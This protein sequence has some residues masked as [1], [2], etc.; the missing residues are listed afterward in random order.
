MA[1]KYRFV[2]GKHKFFDEGYVYCEQ[3]EWNGVPHQKIVIVYL[4]IRPANKP[5]FI[6]KYE[7]YNYLE[8]GVKEVHRH[9]FDPELIHQ[10]VNSIF[11]RAEV[12]A[13]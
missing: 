11:S 10:L 4:G 8:N 12:T 7:T 2:E 5:G 6:Y 1:T 13:H 9:K 3:C